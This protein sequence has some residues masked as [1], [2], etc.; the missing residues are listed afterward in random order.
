M[1]P[2][3]AVHDP[4]KV[5][6]V[7]RI[8]S[9]TVRE[10]RDGTGLHLSFLDDC[11]NPTLTNG[12]CQGQLEEEPLRQFSDAPL[13]FPR[14]L[15]QDPLGRGGEKSGRPNRFSESLTVIPKE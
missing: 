6:F 10:A 12:I 11:D 8:R 1:T 4:E 5:R 3:M 7:D 15:R 13:A 2:V 14:F 9:I